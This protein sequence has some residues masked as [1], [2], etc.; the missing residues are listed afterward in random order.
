MLPRNSE[1][2]AGNSVDDGRLRLAPVALANK[3][4]DLRVRLLQDIFLRQENDPEV[5]AAGPLPKARAVDHQDVFFKEKI[6]HEYLIAFRNF[7]ARKSIE[8]AARGHSSYE[9]FRC[10]SSPS[11]H[12]EH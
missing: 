8:R 4:S 2:G 9:G 1:K 3:V 7:D 6:L 5:L 12:A 11:N 10:R